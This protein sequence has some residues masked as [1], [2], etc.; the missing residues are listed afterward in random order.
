MQWLS[1]HRHDI[2]IGSICFLIAA[3]L[4]FARKLL[5]SDPRPAPAFIAPPPAKGMA[6][7]PTEEVTLP[8]TLK[9]HSKKVAA[10]KMKLPAEIVEDPA[11]EIT[12]T[13]DLKPSDG[14]YTMAAI[15]D[16]STGVTSIIAKEKP[17]PLF[18]LGGES[19]VGLLG[20]T[21]DSG[22]AALVFARQDMLRVGP[23]H[24]FG[25]AG[26]GVVGG[27]LGWGLFIGVSARWK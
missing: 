23:A 13:A 3:G 27:D 22:D 10:K 17:R 21:T 7:V 9:T 15:T 25:A 11:K 5:W 19:E 6:A 18:A 14:G 20:G 16:T 12:A 1:K 2:L 26:A 8:V 4:V 24:L